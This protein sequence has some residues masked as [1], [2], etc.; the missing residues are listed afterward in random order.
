MYYK[1]E[2]KFLKDQ[3]SSLKQTELTKMWRSLQLLIFHVVGW[4][5]EKKA[6]EL[7]QSESSWGPVRSNARLDIGADIE[8]REK[9]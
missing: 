8:Q 5:K 2:S 4:K 9:R 7:Q 1:L 3:L 6:D